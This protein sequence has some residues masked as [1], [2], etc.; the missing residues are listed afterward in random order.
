[1]SAE[2]ED[3]RFVR[4]QIVDLKSLDDDQHRQVQSTKYDII[5]IIKKHW[6]RL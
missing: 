6:P 4:K 5:A 1:M 2:L 3:L